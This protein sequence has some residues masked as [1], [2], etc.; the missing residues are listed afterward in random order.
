[1]RKASPHPSRRPFRPPQNEGAGRKPHPEEPARAGVPKDE[2]DFILV[3]RFGAPQGVR[4]EIR[5][6]SFTRDPLAIAA[7]GPLW[8]GERERRVLH[9]RPLREDMIA[10]TLEGVTDRDAAAALTGRDLYLRRAALPPPEEEEF[11]VADLIGLAAVDEAGAAIGVVRDVLNYG[12]GDILEVAPPEGETL[13]FPFTKAVVP[14]IDMAGRRLVLVP[15]VEDG[16]NERV[17]ER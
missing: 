16:E 15:P 1:M 12:A 11:Y 4:G 3:G 5:I 17:E 14:A 6:K 13:L 2:G 10:A 9:A 7:Y 8:D